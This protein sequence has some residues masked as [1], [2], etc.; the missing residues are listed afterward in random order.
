MDPISV[1]PATTGAASEAEE[2]G[3]DTLR[4][5]IDVEVSTTKSNRTPRASSN[6]DVSA[7]PQMFDFAPSAQMAVVGP[8]PRTD[9]T[10]PLTSV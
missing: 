6:S 1:V 4:D 5:E 2:V 3:T 7:T 8:E 9:N 10:P